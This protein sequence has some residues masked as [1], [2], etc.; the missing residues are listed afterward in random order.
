MTP[1]EILSLLWRSAPVAADEIDWPTINRIARQHRLRPLLHQRVRAGLLGP[2]RVLAEQWQKTSYKSSFRAMQR[3]AEIV[4]LGAILLELETTAVLLKGGALAWRGWF[5]AA[6]RPMRDLDLLLEPAAAERLHRALL[7]KGYSQVPDTEADSHDQ[8]KHLPGLVSP[9]TGTLIELHTRLWDTQ[10]QAELAAER[11]FRLS[12]LQRCQPLSGFP[13]EIQSL[14]DGDTLLH[15]IIH[16]VLD[17]Q[18]N[19]GPLLLFDVVELVRHG[20]IDWAGLWSAA[21]EVRAVRA[22]QLAL[23]L[24]DE[25]CAGLVLDQAKSRY[26]FPD[27]TKINAAAGLLLVD[28]SRKSELGVVG[29]IARFDMR[30]WAGLIGR[31]LARRRRRGGS[32][33]KA[34]GEN[35]LRQLLVTLFHPKS[36][37]HIGDS[38]MVAAWLRGG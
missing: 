15:V 34:G 28:T 6:V 35:T 21:E 31:G 18:F 22:V 30:S 12:A 25:V 16:G 23:A 37:A 36:R 7:A 13:E 5:D 29:R 27:R 1:L 38:L 11:T 14:S 19:N 9:L 17:H 33:G 8:A 26:N 3:R 2:D 20:E 24:V 10:S 32:D 4:C